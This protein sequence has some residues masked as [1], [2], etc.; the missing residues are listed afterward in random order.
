[1]IYVRHRV[2][3]FTGVEAQSTAPNCPTLARVDIQV[4]NTSSPILA[5]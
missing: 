2:A 5:A 1:V 3:P 4:E